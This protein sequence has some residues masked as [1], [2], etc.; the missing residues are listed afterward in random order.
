MQLDFSAQ[1]NMRAERLAV[2]L[3]TGVVVVDQTGS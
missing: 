3:K 2:A 1:E